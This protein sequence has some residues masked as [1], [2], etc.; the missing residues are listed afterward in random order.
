MILHTFPSPPLHGT[1]LLPGDKSISHRAIL[2]AALADG[3]SRAENLLVSG[4]TRAMLDA[5]TALAIPWQLDGTT[6]TVQ[7]RGLRHWPAPAQ[8]INCGNSA[9]T[10][11][12]LAGA[13]AA[14]GVT[15]VLDGT[16]G[17]R[18]RPM[19]RIVNPLQ[20]MGV[21][22]RASEGCAPL[23]LGE[24]D[25]PLTAVQYT[26]PVASAQVKSCLLLAGLVAA[27][28]VTLR[29][30]GP[31][32]DHTE[33]MLR[34]MGVQ[35]DTLHEGQVTLH[36]PTAPLRPLQMTIPGD[37]SSAAFL[38]VAALIVPGSQVT[39]RG[40]G[41]NPTRTGLLDALR[42]MGARI[43]I[44]NAAE[45][46]GEPVGDLTLTADELHGTEVGG[47]LVVRMI[48]EF[49][50]F[51]VAAALAEGQ[52]VVRDATELRHKESDRITALCR[53]L[54]AIGADVTE[55][56]DGFIIN[57]QPRLPGGTVNPHGDHRLA[58]SL[59]V[60]GLA[61]AQGVIVQN[62][63]ITHESFPSFA[64]KLVALGAAVKRDA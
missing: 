35:V 49:P 29:E 61:S 21:N 52:T 34:A 44:S 25:M 8:P 41:L 18:R 23:L 9:T 48:D 45:V 12:L 46:G 16:P 63:E 5:L 3:E 4:V 50:A 54:Q 11:R 20:Q 57:G 30:P 53:E 1:T 58:M 33:R 56:A 26:L 6:L 64:D 10:M 7:G 37:I 17:L 59:A 15:A 47:D 55:T 27:G 32:R 2:F 38:I 19:T 22:I 42:Q 40:V 36:P 28:P 31:S 39:L 43:A 13:L 60:A 24:S 14:S 62:A 51:A